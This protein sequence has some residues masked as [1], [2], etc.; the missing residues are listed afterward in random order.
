MKGKVFIIGDELPE[1]LPDIPVSEN[2]PKDRDIR[3][4]SKFSDM[5]AFPVVGHCMED[6]GI[7][8][9]GKVIVDFK[10]FPRPERLKC[11][12]GDGSYDCCLCQRMHVVGDEPEVVI[13][14]YDGKWGAWHCISTRYLPEHNPHAPMQQGLFA[15]K[16]YGVVIASYGKDGK[17]KWK[18]D[19]STF[20]MELSE[21]PTIHGE[22]C[23][24]P[25]PLPT[26]G[27]MH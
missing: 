26:Q 4:L 11:R 16:I 3:N 25:M 2:Y 1:A 27:A 8:D 10:H 7:E 5:V 20:P 17:L 21:E 18:R 13:K 6:A 15:A 12:G 22:N 9:G 23:G 24:D 19:P 14:K